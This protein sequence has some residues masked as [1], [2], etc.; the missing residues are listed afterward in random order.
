[1]KT[2]LPL[3]PTDHGRKLTEDEFNS[4]EYERGHHYEIIDGKLYVSPLPNIPQAFLEKW[5]MRLLIRYSDSHPEV[6]NYVEVKARVY[7][8]S[9]PELTV[10][11]PDIACY[12]DFPVQEALHELV[13]ENTSPILVAEVVSE[14]NPEKDLERN[15][16]LYLQVPSIREY[17]IIDPRPIAAQPNFLV[18]RRH[19][20]RWRNLEFGYGETY[21]TRLLPGFS[22]LIDPSK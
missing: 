14:N 11:E 17:W 12:H 21:T 3:G 19:G 9:R 22:L 7:V 20:R 6:I 5:L 18:H 10:P 4:S 2:T 13:W 1:M 15:V 8:P 16:E